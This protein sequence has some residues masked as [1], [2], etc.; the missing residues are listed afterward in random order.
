MVDQVN[1]FSTAGSES[2]ALYAKLL[3][4]IAGVGPFR[5]EV[6]KTSVHL[7]RKSAFAGVQFRKQ[8]LMLTI[9][10]DKEI[11][12][13][14]VAKAEQVSKNRWHL[15]TKLQQPTEIDKQLVGW[16]RQAYALCE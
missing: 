10:A 4:A 3:T 6:K 13:A 15:E 16:I 12:N 11:K 5:E 7:M 2:R 8:H 1:A 14:R 9:K